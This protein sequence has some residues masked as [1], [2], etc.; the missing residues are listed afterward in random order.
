[1]AKDKN[2]VLDKGLGFIGARQHEHGY[3]EEFAISEVGSSNQWV[4]A[5]IACALLRQ[6]R[7]VASKQVKKAAAWLLATE[8]PGGG[9]GYNHRTPADAD[10]TANALRMLAGCSA[11]KGDRALLGRLA[12]F[13]ISFQDHDT[14][15]FVTY[16]PSEAGVLARTGWC[17]SEVSV[18]AMAGLALLETDHEQY[19]ETLLRIKTFLLRSRLPDGCWGS[20]WWNGRM[21]G[22][23]LALRFLWQIGAQAAAKKGTKWV[24]GQLGSPLSPFQTALALSVLGTADGGQEYAEHLSGGIARLT[25]AQQPDGGWHSDDMLKVQNPY[26]H[27]PPWKRPGNIPTRLVRDQNRLFTTATVLE[28]LKFPQLPSRCS[29]G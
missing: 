3:W 2:A 15:G 21:Y 25:E 4:T 23:S 7:D 9:W 14:G 5:Y 6:D 10:S 13:L 16:R 27:L 18:T 28:A 20:Y 26:E 11:T 19:R 12:D 1:M 29:P 17:R 8:L 22:T 24:A